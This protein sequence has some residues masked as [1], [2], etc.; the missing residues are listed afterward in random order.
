RA[1]QPGN[2]AA[3][4][5]LCGAS[6]RLMRAGGGPA[7]RPANGWQENCKCA[8]CA[9]LAEHRDFA[10]VR[11]GDPL[12]DGQPQPTAMKVAV[13]GLVGAVEP[14]ED[15]RARLRWDADARVGHTE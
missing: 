6:D 12:A 9:W 14:F 11:I 8:A 4:G 10:L 7:L 2:T 5:R 3:R 15:M 1:H 13:T